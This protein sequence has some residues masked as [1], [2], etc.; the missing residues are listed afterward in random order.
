MVYD[1]KAQQQEIQILQHEN[2]KLNNNLHDKDQQL[3]QAQ[4][5]IA[6]LQRERDN[7]KKKLLSEYYIYYVFFVCF[8][9]INIYNMYVSDMIFVIIG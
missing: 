8:G 5:D 7:L 1:L 9:Y 6:R 2:E 4:Q 3:K